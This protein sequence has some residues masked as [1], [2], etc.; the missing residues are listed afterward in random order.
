M[1][2]GFL[3]VETLIV[4]D[5]FLLVSIP[6]LICFL[7]AAIAAFLSLSHLFAFAILYFSNL[8]TYLSRSQ[9]SG[10]ILFTYLVVKAL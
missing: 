1:V 2:F 10:S 7:N 6:C 8:R 5:P 3:F 9:L 4:R